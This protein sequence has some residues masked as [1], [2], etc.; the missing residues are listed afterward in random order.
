MHVPESIFLS[1]LIR[2]F[3]EKQE[4]KKRDFER[5]LTCLARSQQLINNTYITLYNRIHIR[6]LKRIFT[7][8]VTIFRMTPCLI[9]VSL[10]YYERPF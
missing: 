9:D 2:Y 10:Q 6:S 3:A 4:T 1:M 5:D 7:A 8:S